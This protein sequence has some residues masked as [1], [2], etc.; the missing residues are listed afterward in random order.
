MGSASE[1]GEGVIVGLWL[2]ERGKDKLSMP[3]K[4][5][6]KMEK[7]EEEQSNWA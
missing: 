1:E 2:P 3:S 7:D 6:D 4:G 5:G